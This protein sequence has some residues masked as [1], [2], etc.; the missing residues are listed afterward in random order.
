MKKTGNRIEKVDDRDLNDFLTY[1]VDIRGCSEMTALGY[2][3][4]V[5]GFLS[6][7][8]E[9]NIEKKDVDRETIR[10]F[11]LELNIKGIARSS[12]KRCVSALR[13]FYTY[14]YKY[15]GY[16]TN[17]FEL[18][19]SPKAEKKLP[20]FFTEKEMCDFLDTNSKREDRNAKRDQ[21]ILEL[22]YATGLRASETVGLKISDIDFDEK[23]IKVVGKG[24]K[25][26]IVPFSE[27]AKN[28][29]L[30][31]MNGYRETCIKDNTSDILFINSKGEPL[32]ERGLQ[33]IV[34]ESARK[35]GITINVHPHMIRH[36]YATTLLS[37]GVDI[38]IIQE[39]LGHS[40]IGT[41]SIYTHVTFED[42]RKTYEECFEEVDKE[43]DGE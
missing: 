22:M 41:T 43:I 25:E 34:K 14:L 8:K 9:N 20:S 5:A 2:G 32:S 31:Y 19:S 36:S 30:E 18:V 35:C 42:L 23:L 26:R 38:R 13:H 21:A 15:K 6:F 12:I 17:P 24:E 4:D 16:E 37:N 28:A 7:I 40:S 11:L 1:L 33:Y 29:V 39:L 3:E 27:T 10:T